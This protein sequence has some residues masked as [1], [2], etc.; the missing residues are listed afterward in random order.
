[1]TN[2]RRSFLRATIGCVLALYLPLTIQ[3]LVDRSRW[4]PTQLTLW[5]LSAPGQSFVILAWMKDL[6]PGDWSTR[7]YLALGF[8]L[9]A[10]FLAALL[11]LCR[12]HRP[13]PGIA[14]LLAFFL[15]GT[16]AWVNWSLL[17]QE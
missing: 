14:I 6:I 4:D 13:W 7:F 9:T 17:R 2:R 16:A 15:G 12:Q 11:L 3:L 5:I 10:G 1:M 8:G